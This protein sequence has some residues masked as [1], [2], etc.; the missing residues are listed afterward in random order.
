MAEVTGRHL[1]LPVTSVAPED[2]AARFGRPAPPLDSP[3]SSARTREL[4]GW[5]PTSPGLVDDL[6]EG[7]YFDVSAPTDTW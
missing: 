6:E 1:G 7:H 4:L 5:R 3:A 2:T